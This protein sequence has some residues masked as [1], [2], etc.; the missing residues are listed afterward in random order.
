MEEEEGMNVRHWYIEKKSWK[1]AFMDTKVD[2][3]EVHGF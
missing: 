2:G 1:Y 3:P